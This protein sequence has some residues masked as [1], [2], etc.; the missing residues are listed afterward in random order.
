MIEILLINGEDQSGP[1]CCISQQQ[2][3][4]DRN[5]KYQDPEFSAGKFAVNDPVEKDKSKHRR[6]QLAGHIQKIG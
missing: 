1:R 4:C 3:S 2:Y 6:D 5:D